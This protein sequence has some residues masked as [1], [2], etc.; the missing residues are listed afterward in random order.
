MVDAESLMG[1]VWPSRHSGHA[2]GDLPL[3]RSRL[4]PPDP[5][6][7]Q[8]SRPRLLTMLDGA[9]QRPLT[10]VCAP[11]GTGKTALLS[12]WTRARRCPLPVVWLRVDPALRDADPG[13]SLWSQVLLGLRR[14]AAAPTDGEL[15]RLG[16]VDARRNPELFFRR[17][18][19]SLDELPG[20]T[21][22]VLD[23]AHMINRPEDRAGLELVVTEGRGRLR[24]V[25]C[26]RAPVLP[27]HRLRAEGTVTEIGPRELAFSAAETAALLAAYGQA[28]PP[29]LAA[30]LRHET[31]G[32][33]VGIRLVAAG[34]ASVDASPAGPGA[35]P[36]GD[37]IR[38]ARAAIADFLEAEVLDGYPDRVRRFLLRT[39]VLDRISGPL[40]DAVVAEE[41]EVSPD[42]DAE[43]TGGA[44]DHPER[45]GRPE[46]GVRRREPRSA[47]AATAAALLADL[48]RRGGFVVALDDAVGADG[49]LALGREPADPAATAATAGWYRIHRMLAPVLRSALERDGEDVQELDL[50]AALWFASHASVTDAVRHALRAEDWR[51]LSC[52]LVDGPALPRLL[53]GPPDELRA[54][55]G[56]LP[57]EAVGLA[58]ECAIIVALGQLAS[59]RLASGAA[60]L[61]SA[62]AGLPGTPAG[63]RRALS[64][65]VDMVEMRRAELAGEPEAMLAAARRVLRGAA[66]GADASPASVGRTS[67]PDEVAQAIAMH[68]RGRAELWLGRLPVAEGLLR[69]ACGLARLAGLPEVEASCLGALALQYAMRGRLRQ[70]EDHAL[71]ESEVLDDPLDDFL[72]DSA[73]GP[74]LGDDGRPGSHQ[75]RRSSAPEVMLASALVAAQRAATEVAAELG[76][77][78]RLSATGGHPSFLR[79]LAVVV[80]ARTRGLAGDADDIRTARRTLADTRTSGGPPLYLTMRRAAEADLLVA[81]GSPEAARQLMARDG[82]A[83]RAAPQTVLAFVR[84]SLACADLDTAE[85]TLAPL[86]RADG[87]GGGGL[88]AACVLAAVAAARRDDHARAGGLLARAIALADDEGLLAPFL[89][90]GDEVRRLVDAHPGLADAHPRFVAALRDGGWADHP[91]R[92]DE[93]AGAT[94]VRVGAFVPAPAQPESRITGTGRPRRPAPVGISDQPPR[95][96]AGAHG[97]GRGGPSNAPRGGVPADS[98]ARDPAGRPGGGSDGLFTGGPAGSSRSAAAPTGGLADP[99]RGTW[100]AWQATEDQA[101]TARPD[102]TVRGQRLSDR[103]FAVL[104]Y[105]PTML[106]TAEIAAEMYVSVNTIKTHL[107][108]IYRK[109]DVARRRDAVDRARALRLL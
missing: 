102:D 38:R 101:R 26:G 20:P 4:T 82:G 28:V 63:R 19:N 90:A 70:A 104:S 98:A 39:S 94:S 21:V 24:L 81:A 89:E 93:A 42:D 30:T 23:D 52:L 77:R 49:G 66:S 45:A 62:R 55:A 34:C 84:A 80:E 92:R 91:G 105:L 35:N 83:N 54:L 75:G 51:Y 74:E 56:R 44:A 5:A 46:A 78:A 8:I 79:D 67:R 25:L 12:D 109:L 60:A 68:A 32:W 13:V 7:P 69:E 85:S 17:L 53:F 99:R 73:P 41:T 47:T 2:V 18:V 27:T 43:V 1:A 103:E 87:G 108:S 48:A 96:R 16:T 59:G 36:S 37:P 97:C 72:D 106:T 9:V 22:L 11:A 40:A 58:P 15:G 71:L 6:V 31:E 76:T 64:N 86:L 14:E 61:A 29:R 107:K 65:R 88:V 10:V 57:A 95:E 50:R 100:P 3:V 33:A